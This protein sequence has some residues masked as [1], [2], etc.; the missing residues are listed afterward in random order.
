MIT[1]EIL[2]LLAALIGASAFVFMHFLRPWSQ[3]RRDLERL[4]TGNFQLSAVRER[5]GA[6]IET[7][8]HIKKISELLQKLDRE[9]ADEVLSLRGILSSMVEGILIANRAQR[10]TLVN[11]AL[12]GF[13]PTNLSPLGRTV[14]EFFR[15][16][17]LQKAVE[18]A[19][20]GRAPQQLEITFEEASPAGTP[21]KKHFNI[22]VAFLS[23]ENISQPQAVLLVFQD[24]TAIRSLE[25]TRR[26]FIGNVSHEFKT[27]LAIINGYVE[28]L[29][30]GAIDEPEMT[31]RSL[32]AIHRN[33]QRLTLLIEDLLS[34]SQMES[35]AKLLEIAPINLRD[36]VNNVLENLEPNISERRA[37]I[38]IDWADD[39]VFA[40]AD[41]RRMEQVYWNL[42]S[43]ALRYGDVENLVIRISA[44]L[45][46]GQVVTSFADNG[47]GIPLEDQ[48]HIFERFYRVRKDRARD[49]GGTGLG[50]SIVKNIILAH[51]G[52]ISVQ[53]TPGHGATFFI[54]MAQNP[55][56]AI[57]D[58]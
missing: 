15:R 13:F 39:A 24:V 29:L 1:L 44:W 53:S 6:Y 7:T 27:P 41:S 2:L 18:E 33:V 5:P 46:N 38:E 32:R 20:A 9:A 42:L 56:S 8:S 21:L 16:H 17:E 34:I 52:S 49:A 23:P 3:I 30:D 25:A 37:Q 40:H 54:R 35:R 36:L 45:E 55:Q 58:K 10:I 43:N 48:A 50:L 11:D 12:L 57:N 26:E 22:H 47:Q 19:L 14:L 31:D 28:T 51:G 4:A